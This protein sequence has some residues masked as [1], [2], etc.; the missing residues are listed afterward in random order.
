MGEVESCVTLTQVLI[1][2]QHMTLY[3]TEISFVLYFGRLVHFYSSRFVR[4]IY[5]FVGCKK[6]FWRENRGR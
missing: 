6:D 3:T 5:L 1:V 2:R 4:F